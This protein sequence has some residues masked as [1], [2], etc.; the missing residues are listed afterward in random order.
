MGLHP[1]LRQPK[2]SSPDRARSHPWYPC[3]GAVP[4]TLLSR[5]TRTTAS[6]DPVQNGAPPAPV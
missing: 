2:D 5:G 6:A 1:L 4:R 3:D